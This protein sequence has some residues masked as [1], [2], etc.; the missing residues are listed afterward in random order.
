MELLLSLLFCLSIGP[1][2]VLNPIRI[3]EGSFGGP[4]LFQNPHYVSP[5]DVSRIVLL[6]STKILLKYMFM[7]GTINM[8]MNGPCKYMYMY[9]WGKKGSLYNLYDGVLEYLCN[10]TCTNVHVFRQI[11]LQKIL[12]R[13]SKILL[14]NIHRYNIYWQSWYLFVLIWFLYFTISVSIVMTEVTGKWFK[15]VSVLYVVNVPVFLSDLFLSQ[16]RHLMRKRGAQKYMSRIQAKKSLEMRRGQP[17]YETD[18]T[19]DVFVTIRPED[20]EEDSW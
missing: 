6:Y 4:T 7:I 20:A 10:A 12:T 19:D 9:F 2:F 16:L 5:N 18:P 8:E 14:K 11:T 13:R 1:R 17:S 15:T 3:F